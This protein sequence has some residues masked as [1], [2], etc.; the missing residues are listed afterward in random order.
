MNKISTVK[1]NR[2]PVCNSEQGQTHAI[3][4]AMG[5]IHSDSLYL[6]SKLEDILKQGGPVEQDV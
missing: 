4:C 2:C 3:G 1:E 6:I 5:D